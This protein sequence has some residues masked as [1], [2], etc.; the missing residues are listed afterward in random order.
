MSVE[1]NSKSSF[2]IYSDEK[3]YHLGLTASIQTPSHGEAQL[4]YS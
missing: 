4:R 3:S 1:F 2:V